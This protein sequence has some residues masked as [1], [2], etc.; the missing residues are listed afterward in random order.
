MHTVV[1]KTEV[2]ERHPWVAM[3][4]MQAFTAAK[5]VGQDRLRYTGALFASL[6][7]LGDHLDDLDALTG[8]ADL[9]PYGVE[10]NRAVLE[11]FLSDSHSQGLIER[12]LS[13]DELFA[14]ETM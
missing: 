2:Y 6:P 9:V 12:P 11:K 4:L 10:P 7:W 14:P 3:N 8:G 1:I 5:A 13:V